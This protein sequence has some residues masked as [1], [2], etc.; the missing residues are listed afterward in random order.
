MVKARH[1]IILLFLFLP[2]CF[3]SPAQ[4]LKF[5][6]LSDTHVGSA[7]GAE[8]LSRAVHDI[9]AMKDV[10]FVL[11]SGDITEMGSNDQLI[12]AKR[13][14]DSLNRPYYIVPGNHD[15]KWSESGCTM[16][17]RLWG[18]DRFVFDNHGFRFIGMHEGPIMK[19]GDGHFAPEDLRWI[20]SVLTSM[21]DPDQP[22]IFL[23]HYPLDS[24]IDNWYEMTTRL[25][26]RNVQAVLVGHGHRNRIMDF[27]GIPGVMGRSNLRASAQFGGYTLA[28]VAGDTLFFTERIPVPA[29]AGTE[30][31]PNWH[32]LPLEKKSYSESS[33]DWERPDFSFNELPSSPKTVWSF[34]TGFT[35]ASTPAVW[36]D[37]FIIGNSSGFITCYALSDGKSLWT[38]KTGGAIYSTPAS[39]DGRVV[40]G[41]TD[42]NIY[43]L[44]INTGKLAWKLATESPVVAAAVVWDG[45]VYIG[46][47]D[48]R[49]RAIDLKTGSVRWVFEGLNGFVETKPLIDGDLIVFGAWDTYLYALSTNDGT[50]QWKW[51]NGNPGVLLSPAAVWPVASRGKIFVAAPDRFLTA[52]EAATGRMVWRTNQFTVRETVGISEDGERVYARCMRDTVVAFSASSATPLPLWVSDCGYGYDIDP[53]MPVEKDGTVFFGTKNGLVYALE[54]ET[55]KVLWRYK[56]GVTVVSTPVALDGQSVLV[57]DLDGQIALLRGTK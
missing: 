43:C 54:A 23:T 56:I 10:A 18:N 2:F 40:V 48:R 49:F 42:G 41:S 51:W 32:K 50:L 16:F 31:R 12:L 29:P 39:A 45:I 13:I 1:S 20:D 46:G 27:E 3:Q 47:S 38:Y 30:A 19:M 26:R 44:D 11:L 4:D 52:I 34:K 57:S 22:I 35:V 6:W 7:T 33:L 5:A 24:G 9:N 36:K 17:R 15:T 25:R 14:L 21:S 28:T 37:R 55:G 8:D 53:S